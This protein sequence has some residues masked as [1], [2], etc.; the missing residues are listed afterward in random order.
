[1]TKYG[2]YAGKILYVNLTEE[3]ISTTEVTDDFARMYIGGNGFAARILY[4]EMEAGI[5]PLGPDN[6]YC[7]MAGPAAGTLLSKPGQ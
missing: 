3:K 4:D 7:I 6:I 5:D 2:G 1:M